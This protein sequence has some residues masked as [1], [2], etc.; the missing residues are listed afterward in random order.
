[1]ALPPRHHHQTNHP[2]G[3][4]LPQ[5]HGQFAN[6][7]STASRRRRE[8]E[9]NLGEWSSKVDYALVQVSGGCNRAAPSLKRSRVFEF[10]SAC[11]GRCTLVIE[12]VIF[13]LPEC[14]VSLQRP[15]HSR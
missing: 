13:L 5:L 6:C 15:S 11:L 3:T 4:L 10:D 8:R 9:R 1:M 12:A 14:L 2:A 7:L